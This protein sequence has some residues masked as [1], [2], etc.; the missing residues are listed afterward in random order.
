ML[1]DYELREKRRTL[2][3]TD[4]YLAVQ[5]SVSRPVVVEL[6]RP[7]FS[8]DPAR[9]AEFGALI[10]ARAAVNYP[11][12]SAVFEAQEAEGIHFYARE[13]IPGAHMEEMLRTSQRIKPAQMLA[14][15]RTAAEAL[16]WQEDHG[17]QRAAFQPRHLYPCPDSTP[18]LANIASPVAPPPDQPAEIRSLAATLRSLV[19][20]RGQDVREITHVL[21]LM[22][23][24][25]QHALRTWKEVC[26]E[27]R[28]ALQRLTEAQTSTGDAG[29]RNRNR[30]KTIIAWAAGLAIAGVGITLAVSAFKEQKKLAPRLLDTMIDVPEGEVTMEDGT[31][32]RVKAFSIDQYEV[33]IAQYAQFLVALPHGE[34]NRFDDAR[35]PVIKKDHLPSD[36]VAIYAA[37]Q[38]GGLWQGKPVT[39]NCP[40]TGVDWWDAVAYAKWK[41]R[42]LPTSAEWLLAARGGKPAPPFKAAPGQVNLAFGSI[43]AWWA[44]VDAFADDISPFGVHGMHGNIAEWVDSWSVHPDFPDDKI[45]VFRGG[46]FRFALPEKKEAEDPLLKAW[47][48]RDALYSQP[49]IGFRTASDAGKDKPAS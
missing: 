27:S 40:V 31:V 1:G 8:R 32:T 24:D 33:S 36:W 41:S 16:S 28:N 30:R 19:D 44:E 10:K 4:T 48:A 35:Q 5:R 29:A 22:R 49:F 7:E 6:L 14:L 34:P 2:E 18:R 38:S 37:A 20:A 42:R 23:A 9:V 45:P 39:V 25:G 47:F 43:P 46:H 12:V 21:S 3:T 15:I 11:C 17:I 26:R 13:F